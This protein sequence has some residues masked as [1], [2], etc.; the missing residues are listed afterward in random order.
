MKLNLKRPLIFFDLETTGTNI[1]NDHIVEICYL[2][3]YLPFTEYTMQML[4]TARNSRKL[5]KTSQKILKEQTSP[6]LIP[7]DSMSHYW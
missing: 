5:P 2:K 7:T 6:D 4:L 1:N 3:I